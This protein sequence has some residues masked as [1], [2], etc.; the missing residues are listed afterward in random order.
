MRKSSRSDLTLLSQDTIQWV[1]QQSPSQ[2]D[3]DTGDL[4]ASIILL[5][6]ILIVLILIIIF[7]ILIL[8]VFQLKSG[9]ITGSLKINVAGLQSDKDGKMS[10]VHVIFSLTLTSI[11]SKSLSLSQPTTFTPILSIFSSLKLLLNSSPA[12]S[13][14][15]RWDGTIFGVYLSFFLSC[16][17]GCHTLS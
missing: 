13:S 12:M 11:Q 2:G 7:S 8:L 6:L 3:Q 10:H 16:L 15:A 1:S 17:V 5:I 14:R 9:I 4:L